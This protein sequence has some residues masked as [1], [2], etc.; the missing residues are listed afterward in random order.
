[1]DFGQNLQE[2]VTFYDECRC[3]LQFLLLWKFYCWHSNIPRTYYVR[4]YCRLL[5]RFPTMF[6]R[7]ASRYLEVFLFIFRSIIWRIYWH[8]LLRLW[9][10]YSRK[11]IVREVEGLLILHSRKLLEP[12]ILLWHL[13]KSI[14]YLII[15]NSSQKHWLTGR[16][17]SRCW[18]YMKTSK[19]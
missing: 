7:K 1:M 10:K 2:Y 17:L 14:F 3:S 19:K 15:V 5:W 8:L 16:N 4:N 13:N 18:T 11:L 6:L 12:W 9:S